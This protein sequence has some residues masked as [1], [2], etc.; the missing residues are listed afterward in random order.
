MSLPQTVLSEP[1]TSSAP[2][3]GVSV[4]R[5]RINSV[6]YAGQYI[7]A[8]AALGSWA[9]VASILIG[10]ANSPDAVVRGHIAANMLTVVS[11]TSGAIVVG[12]ALSDPDNLVTNATYVTVFGT[13]S[14]GVGTYTVNNPQTVGASFTG[15][16]SGT[17]LTVTSVT[18]VITAGDLVNGT[19]VPANTTISSQSSGTPGGAGVYVTNNATTSSGNAL[20]SNKLITLASAS[21]ALIQVNA[22]QVPQLVAA[23]IAVST[24]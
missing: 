18:G 21:K 6:V 5:A 8:I 1:M 14:G 7:P 15:T 19:G 12:D 24:T 22:D 16:G 2:I 9:Q 13:G 3:T 23:N 4:P 11:V 20:T 10:G 17:N